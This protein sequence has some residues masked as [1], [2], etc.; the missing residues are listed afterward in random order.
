MA[1]ATG[2]VTAVY[3]VAYFDAL[4]AQ[5]GRTRVSLIDGYSTLGSIPKILATALGTNPADIVVTGLELL[6]AL[7]DLT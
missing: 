7:G 4:H 1:T 3:E 5:T 6:P 2:R